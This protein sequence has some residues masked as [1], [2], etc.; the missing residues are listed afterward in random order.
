MRIETTTTKTI[1]RD[2]KGNVL[3]ETE[4]T[5]TKVL[6]ETPNL[7]NPYYPP[8]DFPQSPWQIPHVTS[9]VRD[10]RWDKLLNKAY[11]PAKSEPHFSSE[12]CTY[13]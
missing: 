10:V 5:V 13:G 3:K 4:T 11:P 1:E 8:G 2:S 7:F 6:K 9:E 12:F